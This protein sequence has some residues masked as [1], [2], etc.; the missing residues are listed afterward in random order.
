MK[1]ERVLCLSVLKN[2]VTEAKQT[3]CGASRNHSGLS[4]HARASAPSVDE[5]PSRRRVPGLE[6]L[7]ASWVPP[8][9]RYHLCYSL[10]LGAGE[11]HQP[12]S[13]TQEAEEDEIDVQGQHQLKEAL[14][15]Q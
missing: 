4:E 10:L 5:A 11:E 2:K 14:P 3:A 12:L 6:V 15:Q 9:L 1:L 7:K 8:L 13:Q